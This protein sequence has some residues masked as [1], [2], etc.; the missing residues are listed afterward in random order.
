MGTTV[1]YV[2]TVINTGN[3]TLVTVPLEDTFDAEYLGYVNAIPVPDTTDNTNG[4]LRWD[5]I[6]GTG[7][8][9]PGESKVLAVTL[10]TKKSTD[11]LTNKQ[12]INVAVVIG[13]QDDKG[14]TLPNK[15]DQ[16]PVRITDPAI[17]ISKRTTSPANGI[18]TLNGEVEFTIRVSNLGD[19]TLVKIPVQDIYEA[20]IIEFVSTS[21]STPSV[22]TNGSDGT[23]N[24]ADITTDLG[25]LA[26]GAS[27]EFTVTFRLISLQDTVN[28]ASTGIAEDENGDKVNP[29]SGSSDANVIAAGTF[30]LWAPVLFG[31]PEPTPT[32]TP[33]GTPGGQGEPECPPA[34]CPVDTLIHPKGLA[35]HEGLQMIFVAS[36]DTDTLIKYNPATNSVVATVASGDEPWDVVINEGL[37]E[38]YVSNYASKDVW[39]YDANT[40]VVKKKIHVGPNPMMMEIFPDINTVAVIVR[41]LNGIAIIENGNVVQYMP[42]GGTGAFGFASDPVNKQLIVG[43]RDTGNVWIIYK[44]GGNWRLGDGSEMKNFGGMERTGPFEIAYNPNNNRIYVISMRPSGTWFVDVIEKQSM[45]SLVTLATV[46]VGSSG[47][48]RDPNVG[49]AGIAVNLTT[50]NVFV[51]DTADGTVT[52]IG[53][54]NQVLSTVTVGPDPFEIAVNDDTQ[55]VYVTLRAGNRLVKFADIFP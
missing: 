55:T 48:D 49:G 53:E 27:V 36:R 51:A 15:Q 13:A 43:N 8:M 38:V 5:D 35:V 7:V 32:P 9:Q 12:T 40:L 25:D 50:N 6:T 31:V 29:V 45:T 42:T 30:K 47:S 17:G 33:T 44:D 46:D 39:V 22:N 20:N 10:I 16:A 37:N 14:N 28:R 19:T 21:I 54:N 18:V 1:S 11:A 41:G 24:W 34:G 26:P 4:K 3:T 2:I 23:L 52:V